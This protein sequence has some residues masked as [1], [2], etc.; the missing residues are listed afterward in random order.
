MKLKPYD[1]GACGVVQALYA[2]TVAH[3]TEGADSGVALCELPADTM[4]IGAIVDVTTA[5]TEAGT[6]TVGGDEEIKDIVGEEAVTATEAG[7]TSVNGMALY[8]EPTAVKVK[9]GGSP[10]AGAADIYLLIVRVPAE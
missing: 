9:V 5:F 8:R 4:V 3:D 10:S 6:L 7:K 1:I 2:G